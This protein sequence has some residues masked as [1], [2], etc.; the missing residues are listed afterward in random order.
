M[1]AIA[2]VDGSITVVDI[3]AL[4]IVVVGLPKDCDPNVEGRAKS[5]RVGSIGSVEESG[6]VA[7]GW[8][9]EEA[10][11]CIVGGGLD[12][13]GDLGIGIVDAIGLT[14]VNFALR[15]LGG[16]VVS[17]IKRELVDQNKT[18]CEGKISYR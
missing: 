14:G 17:A 12:S 5:H 6:N 18:R 9:S 13:C 8:I 10:G 7:G 4:S 2:D 11:T 3:G 1:H 15:R 16:I